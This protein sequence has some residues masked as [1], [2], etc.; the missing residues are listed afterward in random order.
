MCHWS[1]NRTLLWIVLD[2]SRNNSTGHEI[3]FKRSYKRDSTQKAA[4]RY[5]IFRSAESELKCV[6]AASRK[7]KVVIGDPVLH[8]SLPKIKICIIIKY[9]T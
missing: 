4:L 2:H 9:P 1:E 3:K 7:E 5:S 6:T 8:R